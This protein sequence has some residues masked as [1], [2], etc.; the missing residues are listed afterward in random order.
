M[1]GLNLGSQ[2]LGCV[3]VSVFEDLP[4]VT[5]KAVLDFHDWSVNS[6]CWKNHHRH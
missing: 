1:L 4:S 6:R 5:K 3:C 2:V